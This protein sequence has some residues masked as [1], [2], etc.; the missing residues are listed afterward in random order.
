MH[1][2]CGI[3]YLRLDVKLTSDLTVISTFL[4]VGEV[5]GGKRARCPADL[6]KICHQ[7]STSTFVSLLCCIFSPFLLS[8]RKGLVQIFSLKKEIQFT[9]LTHFN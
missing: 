9:Q 5:L 8:K 4:V 3:G 2:L 1:E 7:T 6:G